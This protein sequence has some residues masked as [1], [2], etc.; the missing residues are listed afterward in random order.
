MNA[1]SS[2]SFD[3]SALKDPSWKR[4]RVICDKSLSVPPNLSRLLRG[5]WGGL[6]GL[7][8]MLRILSFA[9]AHPPALLAAAG[10][11]AG[12]RAP[13][14]EVLEEAIT[15]LGIRM[16]GIVLAINYAVESLLGS[17]PPPGWK[18]LL[19][20]MMSSV[21]I[22]HIFGN[23]VRNLGSELGAVLGF[24]RYVGHLSLMAFNKEGYKA[25]FSGAKGDD[26]SL[27]LDRF[28]CEAYQVGAFALQ[29]LGF[30]T[31][32][33]TALVLAAGKLN[34]VHVKVTPQ[35]LQLRAAYLWIEALQ[36]GRNFPAEIA[37][38]ST[39]GEITPPRDS[40]T[41]NQQLETLHAEVGRVRSKGSGW[42]WHLQHASYQATAEWLERSP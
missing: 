15:Q 5:A 31:D 22:G 9:G 42:L 8:E 29:E 35:I 13:S 1:P 37:V 18:S 14:R 21:E 30:G 39:F 12:Q 4:A 25:C 6:Y 10:I 20:E 28:G 32:I 34:S 24:S 26:P 2:L 40:S 38:R 41:R 27:Q 11:D 17:N 3:D 23:R 19:Q 7:Q 16:S 33:S 36:L